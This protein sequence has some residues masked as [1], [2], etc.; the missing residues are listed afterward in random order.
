VGL[1][2]EGNHADVPISQKK[3]KCPTSEEGQEAEVVWSTRES[4]TSMKGGSGAVRVRTVDAS[5]SAGLSFP[6]E[7]EAA[8]DKT[9]VVVDQLTCQ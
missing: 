4:S 3:N 7:L 6:D 9:F 2:V 5:S 1:K 8:P